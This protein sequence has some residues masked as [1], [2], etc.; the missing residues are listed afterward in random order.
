MLGVATVEEEEGAKSCGAP[1]AREGGQARPGSWD[2]PGVEAGGRG[3][4]VERVSGGE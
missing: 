4:G 2:A 3:T 1:G